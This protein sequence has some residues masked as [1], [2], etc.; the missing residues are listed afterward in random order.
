VV[1][2][3]PATERRLEPRVVRSNPASIKGG[4]FLHKIEKK[5]KCYFWKDSAKIVAF[6]NRKMYLSECSTAASI[7]TSFRLPR[8]T[9][10]PR[11]RASSDPW[12]SSKPGGSFL[13]GF[14]SLQEKS[15][16]KL[17]VAT[18]HRLPEIK[19]WRKK[20]IL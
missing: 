13:D 3:P 4:S 16:A 8:G 9:R 6:Y 18:R 19:P 10:S 2:S 15:H 20:L 12:R 7:S 5:Q 1:L 11:S 17:T 14:S